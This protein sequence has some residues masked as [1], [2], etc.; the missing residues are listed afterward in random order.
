[1]AKRYHP[2]LNAHKSK[3]DYKKANVK[4]Q[5]INDAYQVL[6]QQASKQRYDE[7]INNLQAARNEDQWP[8][9]YRTSSSVNMDTAEAGKYSGF[10]QR[11]L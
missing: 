11:V 7:L 3:Q 6:S 4:F 5:K 9:Q 1:M 10:Y 8:Q 2:D